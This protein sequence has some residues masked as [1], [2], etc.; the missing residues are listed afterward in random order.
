MITKR[1]KKPIES[2]SETEPYSED[3]EV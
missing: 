1:L 2:E 3:D